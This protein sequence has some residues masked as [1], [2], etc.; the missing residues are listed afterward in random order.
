MEININELINGIWLKRKKIFIWATCGLI[1]GIIIALSIPEEYEA[2]IIIVN[3]NSS[4]EM[5]QSAGALASI[6]GV[7]DMK[8]QDG[9]NEDIYPAI[10]KSSPF[11]ME[12]AYMEIKTT[13]TNK[14]ELHQYILEN[15]KTAWWQSIL[16]VPSKITSIFKDNNNEPSFK[17]SK[18]KQE[19]F[20]EIM[21]TKLYLKLNEKDKTI[22]LNARFQDPK[23]AHMLADSLFV[24]LEKYVNQYKTKKARN[25]LKVS[26]VMLENAKNNY[27][28]LD[29]AYA[30][31]ADR[32][33]NVLSNV[34]KIKLERLS[35]EKDL[36]FRIYNQ[37][38]SQVES[39]RITLQEQTFIA[40]II[41]PA[42]LPR[43]PSK[44]NKKL[45]V[46]SLIFIATLLAI[47]VN[48]VDLLKQIINNNK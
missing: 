36:S 43:Y 12:F 23:V 16:S 22:Y 29:E 18:I 2:S 11:L 5:S 26:L 24:N 45:I 14:M 3:E 19:N 4:N 32:N 34:A 20:V 28:E 9:I 39:D 1:I 15:Q 17:D 31:L 6:M 33:L 44:P 7:G 48:I 21:S 46:F 35:N 25:N 40:T 10:I 27:Y 37:I 13:E 30:T 42:R 41:E 8:S 38:Y 47:T